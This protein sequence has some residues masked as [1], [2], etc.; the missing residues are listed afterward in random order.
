MYVLLPGPP[1]LK[2]SSLVNNHEFVQRIR[3][4]HTHSAADGRQ[5]LETVWMSI[6][7]NS[8]TRASWVEYYAAI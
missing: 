8:V 4:K 2:N 5:K 3:N 7:E 1:V 6:K